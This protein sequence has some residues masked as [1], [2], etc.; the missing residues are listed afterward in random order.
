M[1]AR[2]SKPKRLSRNKRALVDA[3]VVR[4]RVEDFRIYSQSLI[5]LDDARY[6]MAQAFSGRLEQAFY[7]VLKQVRDDC[8]GTCHVPLNILENVGPLSRY[9]PMAKSFASNSSSRYDITTTTQ[10]T[11][12]VWLMIA[13]RMGILRPGFVV[14]DEPEGSNGAF[15]K[16]HL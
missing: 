6:A 1:K 15:F 16:V 2:N 14:R 3:A 9:N 10:A 5:G 12:A 4:T 7:A 11:V 8:G 13:G